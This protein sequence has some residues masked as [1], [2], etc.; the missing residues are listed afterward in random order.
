MRSAGRASATVRGCCIVT[1]GKLEMFFSTGM[2]FLPCCVKLHIVKWRNRETKS[3]AVGFCFTPSLGIT[4]APCEAETYSFLLSSVRAHIGRANGRMS[5]MHPLKR[6]AYS[7]ASARTC[8]RYLR[9]RAFEVMT[10][11]PRYGRSG[12]RRLTFWWCSPTARM[13]QVGYITRLACVLPE[14]I[15]SQVVA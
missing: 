3:E 1:K 15:Q 11:S 14:Q 5:S 13:A 2:C 8:S 10:F 6:C 12:N 7:Q 4:I 9:N